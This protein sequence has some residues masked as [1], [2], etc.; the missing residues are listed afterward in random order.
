MLNGWVKNKKNISARSQQKPVEGSVPLRKIAGT[1][2]F[3]K[4]WM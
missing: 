1:L 4:E 2:A 3:L